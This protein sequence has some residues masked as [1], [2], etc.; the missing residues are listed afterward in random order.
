MTEGPTL[1]MR[2]SS[3]GV[4]ARATAP[5]PQ[6]ILP[7]DPEMTSA[8]TLETI[9]AVSTEE[10]NTGRKSRGMAVAIALLVLLLAAAGWYAVRLVNQV[11]PA[12]SAPSGPPASSA[13]RR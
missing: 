10:L 11:K 6:A 1:P 5:T 13:P 8:P 4:E 9:D 12:P 2:S 3:R 7:P